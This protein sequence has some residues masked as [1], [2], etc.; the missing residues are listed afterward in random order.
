MCISKK[1]VLVMTCEYCR[2]KQNVKEFVDCVKGETICYDCFENIPVAQMIYEKTPVAQLI[3][4]KKAEEPKEEPVPVEIDY[5][6]M[7]MAERYDIF[8]TEMLKVM[9]DAKKNGISV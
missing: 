4:Q 5:E 1:P 7:P 3:A 6:N 9:K 2:V 8:Q